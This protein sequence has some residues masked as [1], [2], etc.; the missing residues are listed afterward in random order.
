VAIAMGNSGNNSFLPQL[1]AWSAGDDEVLAES[2]RW[3]IG[4]I[5]HCQDAETNS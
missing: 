5:R 3:A 4:Q 1:E 2:S